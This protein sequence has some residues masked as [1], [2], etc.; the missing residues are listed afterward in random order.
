V[1]RIS[2]QK[3]LGGTFSSERSRLDRR[4]IALGA[5]RFIAERA[6][7]WPDLDDYRVV[8]STGLSADGVEALYTNVLA[9]FENAPS[10]L[11][12]PELGELETAEV[13]LRP[14]IQVLLSIPDLHTPLLNP[15]SQF[16]HE[17]VLARWLN[18]WG[19]PELAG[20]PQFKGEV[21]KAVAYIGQHA[22]LVAWGIG[23]MYLV[24][25]HF[26]DRHNVPVSER[27]GAVPLF[28]RFG[29]NSLA[30]GLLGLIGLTD[31]TAA[32]IL[33]EAF[34]QQFGEGDVRIESITRWVGRLDEDQIVSMFPDDLRG[35]AGDVL[36]SFGLGR[37]RRAR[38]RARI[39]VSTTNGTDSGFPEGSLVMV[40][41]SPGRRA[42]LTNVVT[43]R[44]IR[45]GDQNTGIM[46]ELT[47]RFDMALLGTVLRVEDGGI[48]VEVHG[49]VD[50]E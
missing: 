23:S 3:I 21:E 2:G 9:L 27:L 33:G 19:Y 7:T 30:V 45:L 34:V 46:A 13:W 32:R 26:G 36:A 49:Q 1:F 5:T 14:I 43:G 47:R 16:P 41:W 37:E 20:L 42:I 35:H 10:V 8:A 38:Q 17:A 18:Y 31:R 12:N 39:S 50:V 4:E 6:R 48:Q 40:F 11:A 28:V 25:R 15:D 29:V 44:R 22:D 24:A